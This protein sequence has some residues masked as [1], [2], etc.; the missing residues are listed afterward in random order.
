MSLIK[1]KLFGSY[2]ALLIKYLS[3]TCGL[4]LA[5]I[6]FAEKDPPN[7]QVQSSKSPL[8]GEIINTKSVEKRQV[9]QGKALIE[10]M[11]TGKSAFIGRLTLAAHAKVP[12]HRDPTEE[13]L[14]IEQGQGLITIDGQVSKVKQ[15]DLIYMPAHAEVSFT[16]GAQK[17]IALQI[18]AGPKS[19]AKY[20]KW[21]RVT[22][23]QDQ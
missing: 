14:L 7:L 8:K 15:G 9:G 20:N 19:A 17:L 16:N 2:P 4:C 12:Q 5:S 1:P 10:L 18:F 3:L 11:K 22:S 13:Y 6:A 23:H 21:Q